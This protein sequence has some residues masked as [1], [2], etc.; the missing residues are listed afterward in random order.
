MS[1]RDRSGQDRRNENEANRDP[2]AGERS[3]TSS[4]NRGRQPSF[5][6]ESLDLP[7]WSGQGGRPS[8]RDAS[9]RST[10]G[11]SRSTVPPVRESRSSNRRDP[12]PELGDVFRKPSR[13]AQPSDTESSPGSTRDPYERL[14]RV[15]AKPPR[16]VSF[17]D[18]LDPAYDPGGYGDEVV[19][20]RSRSRRR[21]TAQ[22]SDRA[23]AQ[24]RPPA[25]QQIGGMIAAAAPQTRFIASV[26]GIDLLSVVLM[27]A[28]VAGRTS[29]MPDW[30]PIHLNAE[31]APDLWGTPASLWRIPLMAVML[32][33]MAC[34]FAWFTS[35][36]DPF[37]ARFAI[38]ATI[39]LQLL[40]W[41]AL[42]N[43]AW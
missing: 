39:L 16:P 19:E 12:I 26:I 25:T 13:G 23:P 4:G 28:T 41:I 5:D 31:G 14:R 1:Q 15:A 7:A 20:P 18:D 2:R 21:T 43:L 37:A 33:L 34:A 3:V 24:Y 6:D 32:T 22:Y 40:C 9:E 42:I 11:P 38:G 17:E 35:R 30:F 36:R 29:S 8:N 27:A 10:S